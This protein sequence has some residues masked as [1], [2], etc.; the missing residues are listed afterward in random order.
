MRADSPFGIGCETQARQVVGLPEGVRRWRL[1]ET[2]RGFCVLVL[3]FDARLEWWYTCRDEGGSVRPG[4]LYRRLS[5]PDMAM[6]D[7][8]ELTVIEEAHLAEIQ[9]RNPDPDVAGLRLLTGALVRLLKLVVR[10]QRPLCVSREEWDA[11]IR[12]A[13]MGPGN[14]WEAVVGQPAEPGAV[15]PPAARHQGA[16]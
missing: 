4:D 7:E 11:Q 6:P 14:Q 8:G 5:G 1:V 13:E 16:G 2:N 12:D 3:L 9:R 10:R 15:P